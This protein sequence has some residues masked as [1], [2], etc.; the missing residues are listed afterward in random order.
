MIKKHLIDVR[1]IEKVFL[2]SGKNETKKN[3]WIIL[4]NKAFNFCL[5]VMLATF[6]VQVNDIKYT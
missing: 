4:T 1:L 6:I 5:N 3:K 2:G